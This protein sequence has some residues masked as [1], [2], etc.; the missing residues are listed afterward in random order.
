MILFVIL[1]TSETHLNSFPVPEI[2]SFCPPKQIRNY[3]NRFKKLLWPSLSSEFSLS[4]VKVQMIL[5]H[6]KSKQAQQFLVPSSGRYTSEDCVC[7]TSDVFSSNKMLSYVHVLCH[8]YALELVILR[9]L[10]PWDL[11]KCFM[12]QNVP[13]SFYYLLASENLQLLYWTQFQGNYI[14]SHLHGGKLPV[15]ICSFSQHLLS[16]KNVPAN[17]LSPGDRQWRKH[18]PCP[19]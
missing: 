10:G 11:L 19:W 2:P 14:Q 4:A 18:S 13:C 6:Y 9:P 7:N 3:A 12:D 8:Q 16:T 17:V 15:W 5:G 1:F